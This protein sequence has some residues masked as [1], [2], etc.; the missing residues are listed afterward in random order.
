MWPRMVP[1]LIW[2]HLVKKNVRRKIASTKNVPKRTNGDLKKRVD[3]EGVPVKNHRHLCLAGDND[4]D[5]GTIGDDP[6]G[7]LD[8]EEV[9]VKNHPHP[10][11]AVHDENGGTVANANDPIK[12]L[13]GEGLSVKNHPCRVE[14][15]RTASVVAVA[16]GALVEDVT[17][18]GVIGKAQVERETLLPPVTERIIND[19]ATTGVVTGGVLPLPVMDMVDEA[20]VEVAVTTGVLVSSVMIVAETDDD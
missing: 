1:I 13:D 17:D 19:T 6:I 4:E 2:H 9:P 18:T 11:L 12:N 8:G 16:A 3:T 7:N 20:K 15:K 14:D 10:C 5:G